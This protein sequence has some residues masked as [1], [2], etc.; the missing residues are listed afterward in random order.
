MLDDVSWTQTHVPTQMPFKNDTSLFFFYSQTGHGEVR[1]GFLSRR[2]LRGDGSWKS[3]AK[4]GFNKLYFLAFC[5]C[6][7]ICGLAFHSLPLP[8][9]TLCRG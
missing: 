3:G 2:A 5:L 6:D 8:G 4:L 1:E 7:F 9:S